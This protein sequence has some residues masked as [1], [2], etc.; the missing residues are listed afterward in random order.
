MIVNFRQGIVQYPQSGGVQKFLIPTGN[1]V[2]VSTTNGV[3]DISFAHKTTNYLVTESA[4]VV[5]AWGPLPTT[6]IVWL[7]W[8]INTLTAAK[9][10]GFTSVQPIVQA[11]APTPA[12]DLHWFD[13]S[14]NVMRVYNGTRWQEK[15]RVFAAM[16][17]IGTS[18]FI[19]VSALST[20]QRFD[21]TQ[22]GNN[23][24]SNT[25]RIIVDNTARPITNQSN[26][27]FTTEDDFFV[28]GSPINTIRL[29]ANILTATPVENVAGYQIV[30]F[31]EF[32][33][34]ELASYHNLQTSAIA[35][36]MQDVNKGEVGAFV[37]QGIIT[38]PSWN[39]TTV[40][41][42]LWVLEEGILVDYDPH[43]TDNVTY[44]TGKAPVGRV[45]GQH[46]IIFDQ[47]LGGKGDK[48]DS[49]LANGGVDVATTT[50]LG[51]V[52][53]TCDPADPGSPFVVETSDPRMSN[54]RKPLQHIHAA[55][56]IAP[57]AYGALISGDL[58]STLQNID[59]A[60]LN[61]TGDVMSGMLT[62]AADPVLPMQAATKQYADMFV[63]LAQKGT[64]NGVA[65]LDGMGKIDASQLPQI[66]LTNTFVVS[67]QDEML[68]L[69]AQTGDLAVR[70]DIHTTYVLSGTNP[71]AIGDWQELLTSPDGVVWIDVKPAE[72]E[73]GIVTTGGPIT[74]SGQVTISLAGDVA[75]IENLTGT[76]VAHRVGDNAWEVK[77]VELGTG[78]TTVNGIL[79][80]QN[81]GTG[82][83]SATTALQNLG[84]APL[85]GTGASGTWN[86]SITGN[87]ASVSNGVYTTSSYADPAWITS[88]SPSKVVGSWN[89]SANINTV[90]AEVSFAN[91]TK[92]RNGKVTTTAVT[93]IVLDSFGNTVDSAKYTISVKTAN[94]A[95]GIYDVM[96]TKD[97]ANVVY[98]MQTGAGNDTSIFDATYNSTI[99]M[100]ELKVTP[101][102]ASQTDYRYSATLFVSA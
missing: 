55:T 6:G 77:P 10:Y 21:G 70:T 52:K 29:E 42:A 64:A 25:G 94:G 80:M 95:V 72:G 62:L 75:A 30:R 7:Y 69:D 56:D 76:G 88:L 13:T 67:T 58:Q 90:A 79:P 65:M 78:S 53:L 73:T 98:I 91:F 44:P 74:S 11:V 63:P 54:A 34:V 39:W 85:T 22:I 18:Q 68:L 3:T 41:K 100:V 99:Q 82:A 20:Q 28:N 9:T 12:E 2:S 87:A 86:I 27:F 35:I 1:Y 17:N 46:S 47:G 31:S 16:Y 57:S 51:R 24:K 81:G 37:V 36:A 38:N 89:G 19:S 4:N 49:A 83:T 8:D 102:S 101:A 5:N 93:Q 33:S 71:T 97:S 23:N 92:V 61:K 14:T 15:I 26:E 50:D 60:K 96:I 40:G 84:G 43:T 32:D 45:I 59:N 66:T 48:G